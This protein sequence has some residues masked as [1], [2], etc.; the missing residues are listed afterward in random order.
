MSFNRCV[1]RSYRLQDLKKHNPH[2]VEYLEERY[3]TISCLKVLSS[4]DTIIIL[5]FA[6]TLSVDLMIDDIIHR[7][8]P[9][10]FKVPQTPDHENIGENK[11]HASSINQLPNKQGRESNPLSFP[12][13]IL[14]STFSVRMLLRVLVVNA[15]EI[16]AT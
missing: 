11:L 1:G 5:Y 9:H 13:L 2:T 6:R 12:R 10:I 7:W 8:R 14:L 4:H 16:D 15:W 3:K